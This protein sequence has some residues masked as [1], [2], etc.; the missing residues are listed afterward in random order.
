VDILP[1]ILEAVGVP[2]PPSAQGRSL[3]GDLPEDRYVFAEAYT[4]RTVNAR[5]LHAI[6]GK[7]FKLIRRANGSRELY[8][9]RRDP[10]ER[11]NLFA[12]ETPIAAELD[13]HLESWASLARPS[14]KPGTIDP[15]TLQRLKALGYIR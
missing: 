12:P 15:D 7:G 11:E 2:V 10:G 5:A 6:V 3:V 4:E 1:T 13:R 14:N 8:D 9:L